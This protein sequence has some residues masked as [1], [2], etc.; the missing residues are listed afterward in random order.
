MSDSPTG[1]FSYQG[2]FRP[3]ETESRDMTVFKDDDG[4]AYLIYSSENN[5]VRPHGR[6]SSS[7]AAPQR[8]FTLERDPDPL[9]V[10]RPLQVTHISELSDCYTTAKGGFSRVHVNMQREAPAVFKHE[11]LPDAAGVAAAVVAAAAVVVVLLVVAAAACGGVITAAACCCWCCCLLLLLLLWL[12]CLLLLLLLVVVLL[13][14]LLLLLV[15]VV[16]ELAAVVVQGLYYMATSGCTGWW[17]NAA[18]VHVATSIWGPW[19]S[20]GNP[21]RSTNATE[22]SRT[23]GSQGAAMIAFTQ[24]PSGSLLSPLSFSSGALMMS[25]P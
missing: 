21:C 18:E 2:S 20:L 8:S 16:V 4:K 22:R 23:F 12:C 10:T 13:L 5:M 9:L 19:H 1:N 24:C 25:L 15:V 11:V 3:Q 17:P 6:P 7:D 14:L